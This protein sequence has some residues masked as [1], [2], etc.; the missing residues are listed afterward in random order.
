MTP[1][2]DDTGCSSSRGTRRAPG[3]CPTGSDAG[4]RSGAPGRLSRRAF[5]ATAVG[6]AVTL[7]GCQ[8]DSNR[9]LPAEPTGTWRQYASDAG[10]T[11]AS[12]ASVP[13]RGNVAWDGGEVGAVEPLVADGTVFAAA[14][15]VAAFDARSG[16]QLWETPLSGTADDTPALTPEGLL[17]TAGRDLVHLDREDGAE[18]WSR[19]LPR[20]ADG[21]ITVDPPLATVPLEA[22]RGRT[23]LVAHDVD[24]GDRR[25][26]DATL[27]ASTTAI[28]GERVYVTGYRQDGNTGILRALAS[29]DGETM[30]TVE[31]DHPD[32]VPVLAAGELLVGDGGTL[33][34]HSP[35]DG[36]RNRT[37]G[38]YGDRL[39]EPP[40]VADGTA[41]VT[42]RDPEVV[43][44]SVD[45]GSVDWRVEGGSGPGVAVGREAVVVS[46]EMLPDASAAGVAAIDRAD[47]SVRWE[48][49]IQGFDAFP[50]TAPA[51]ADG[52]VFFT[53]NQ[54]SGVVALAD[55]PPP[56][57]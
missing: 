1:G 52:A 53:S 12:D 18:L 2:T 49:S 54:H 23:G 29:A 6:A 24:A 8:G 20:P 3:R 25:W 17:V 51:L 16:E 11:G 41:Y 42:S 26:T 39:D 37:L 30:W 31:L 56:D 21:A 28:D 14:E 22:R 19:Q 46:T 45:D 55:L 9:E 32:T 44:V 15:G 38:S 4:P 57:R 34:V 10:N 27:S 47:G 43:A 7:S 36:D 48:F 5:L 50:S 40:A 13:D 35:D 33:G